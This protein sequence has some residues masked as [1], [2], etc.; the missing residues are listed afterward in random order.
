MLPACPKL[1]KQL[2]PLINLK[3]LPGNIRISTI[4]ITCGL[5]TDFKHKN[6]GK[7]FKKK[8]SPKSILSVKYG[9]SSEC[10]GSILPEKKTRARKRKNAKRVFFNQVTLVVCSTKSKNVN[11]KLFKNGSIQMTGCRNLSDFIN[12]MTVLCKEVKRKMRILN[13]KKYKQMLN[14]PEEDI[15]P[16]DPIELVSNPENVNVTKIERFCIKMINSD[17]SVGIKID[18]EKFYD[19]LVKQGIDC[20]YE[21]NKHAAVNIKYKYKYNRKVKVCLDEIENTFKWETKTF[22]TDITVLVFESGNIIITAAKNR[23]H[24]VS[25]YNFITKKISESQAD[26]VKPDEEAIVAATDFVL[27]DVDLSEFDAIDL[28]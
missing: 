28:K 27:Q 16:Y 6:I 18:R 24:I 15:N 4:T 9:D 17:F 3:N 23:D 5:D 10:S 19:M 2:E 13:R 1:Q 14:N 12:V 26:I 20:A 25:A 8:L 7:C 21:P 11:V 22:T